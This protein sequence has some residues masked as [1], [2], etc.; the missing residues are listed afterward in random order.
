MRTIKIYKSRW[1]HGEVD[2]DYNFIQWL[3]TT[4]C[5]KA[6][7]I[8]LVSDIETG[9]IFQFKLSEFPMKFNALEPYPNPTMKH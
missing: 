4:E 5:E 3:T 7:V 1:K 6:V 2:T 8:A 9:Q